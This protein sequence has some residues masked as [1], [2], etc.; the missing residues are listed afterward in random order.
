MSPL[1]RGQ[2]LPTRFGGAPGDYQLAEVD[3][4]AQSELVLRVSPRLRD[5]DP[6]LLRE[7]FRDTLGC[8]HRGSVS[9]QHWE[10]SSALRVAIEEPETTVTGKVH[11][12]RLRG[13][14]AAGDLH[15]SREP[16]E[17]NAPPAR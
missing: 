13:S 12:V 15:G 16:R 9:R 10:F 17:H 11:P 4:A 3:G 6:A 5:V 14:F 8:L 1:G 2:S 7:I